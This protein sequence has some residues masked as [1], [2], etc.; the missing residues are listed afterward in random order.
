MFLV[1]NQ[2]AIIQVKK[3]HGRSRK[4]TYSLSTSDLWHMPVPH[5]YEQSV[6]G[7]KEMREREKSIGTI[8]EKMLTC[9]ET[10]LKNM[11]QK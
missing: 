9:L 5:V 3:G 8:E 7:S 2:N 11:R 10:G 1:W 4:G 6:D